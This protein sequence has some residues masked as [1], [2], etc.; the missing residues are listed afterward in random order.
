MAVLDNIQ[1]GTITTSSNSATATITTVDASKSFVIG[2]VAFSN[3]QPQYSEW[4][5]QLNSAGTQ[6]EVKRHAS[7]GSVT[8]RYWVMEFSSGVTVQRG[9]I[10]PH[11]FT[12]TEY[13][14]VGI[15]ITE[16]DPDKTFCLAT[17]RK[18]GGTFNSDDCIAARLGSKDTFSLLGYFTNND[19]VIEYQIVEYDGCSVTRWR[20]P[21]WIDTGTSG[22]VPFSGTTSNIMIL[23]S[24]LAQISQAA[25]VDEYS[26]TC[27]FDTSG[28]LEWSRYT[29]S[30][31][32]MLIVYELVEFSDGTNVQHGRLTF[33]TT[34][35]SKS[36]TIT[37]VG[38]GQ[39]CPLTGA[40]K[41]MRGRTDYS[42]DDLWSGAGSFD[43]S[44]PSTTSVQADRAAHLSSNA[45]CDYQV[46][47]WN[48]S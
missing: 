23:T 46:V 24:Q 31:D 21:I 36:D 35:T 45:I 47:E 18:A 16:V 48:N 44:L 26:F 28:D 30:S 34:E 13:A 10:T 19:M 22:T 8:I 11:V 38:S 25:D 42:A 29:S 41:H 2:S 33:G 37:A 39:A 12:S 40:Y 27:R 3:N 20:K 1:T 17:C 15:G 5:I 7:S 32:K 4:S 43:L 14:G 6:V 9:S